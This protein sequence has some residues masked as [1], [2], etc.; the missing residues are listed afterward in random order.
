MS[1]LKTCLA[2]AVIS[3]VGCDKNETATSGSA[4]AQLIDGTPNWL[5]DGKDVNYQPPPPDEDAAPGS[6]LQNASKERR[7]VGN[8]VF[9]G[10]GAQLS[11][12]WQQLADLND[13]HGFAGQFVGVSRDRLILYGGSNFPGKKVWE[14]GVK[15]W[16]RDVFVLDELD[17][18]WKKIGPLEGERAVGYGVN[19]PYEDDFL[20]IGGADAKKHYADVFALSYDG[21]KLATRD[22]PKLPKPCAYS[23][24]VRIGDMVYVAGGIETP[25]AVRTMRTF[26]SLDLKNLDAGWKELPTWPGPP[27]MLSLAAVRDGA[28][29]LMSGVDLSPDAFGKPMRIYHRDAYR[30]MPSEGWQKL[31]DL[32]R[33]VVAAPSPAMIFENAIIVFGGDDGRALGYKPPEN[34]PGFPHDLFAFAK[35]DEKDQWLT[36]GKTPYPIAVTPLVEWKNGYVAA[37]G[38]LRPAVRSR[39]VWLVKT[40]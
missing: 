19:V 24:G 27:R 35:I 13:P 22:L 33:A 8:E 25:D 5:Q 40:K 20:C 11:E 39:A 7:I 32:P 6:L 36:I 28:F 18:Q 38:E 9:R 34:H 1:H 17:A 2:I 31:A 16:Y 30:Y 37:S 21:E 10:V 12:R 4:P 29:Y 23:C 15:S 3:L 14:G 26:W